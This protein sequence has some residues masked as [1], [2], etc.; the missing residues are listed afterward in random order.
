M[1]RRVQQR[2]VFHRRGAAEAAAKWLADDYT[3]DANALEQCLKL[4]AENGAIRHERDSYKATVTAMREEIERLQRD[5]PM[6]DDAAFRGDG[7]PIQITMRQALINAGVA[8]DEEAKEVDNA[9]NAL[10]S[11]VAAWK[12]LASDMA[13]ERAGM[14]ESIAKLR[15]DLAAKNSLLD[16]IR[17]ERETAL[18]QMQDERDK[19]LADLAAARELLKSARTGFYDD[20]L[21]IRARIDDFLRREE[22]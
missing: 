12:D 1:V 22:T 11:N 14:Y 21:G 20:P 6:I 17:N 13:A 10:R 7:T 9:I 8:A 15:A 4:A 3:A 16:E 5:G 18:H 2:I 19:A